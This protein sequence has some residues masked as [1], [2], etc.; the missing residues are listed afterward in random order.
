MQDQGYR[1]EGVGRENKYPASF[2]LVVVVVVLAA[3]FL[4]IVGGC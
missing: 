1:I 3:I 2:I 4:C